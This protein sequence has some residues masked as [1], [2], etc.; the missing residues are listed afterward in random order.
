MLKMESRLPGENNINY[1][2]R[3]IK[4]AI[5]LLELQPG[6]LLNVGELSET[7]KVSSTPI[8]NAL[9]KL[10]QEHLV[11]LIPQVGS[12][13]SKIDLDLVEEAA[14]LWFVLEKEYLKLAC[15]FFPED[16]MNQLKKNL[17]SQE[18]LLNEQPISLNSNEW[19]GRF[20]ELDENFHSIIFQ[21]HHR[22]TT[23]KVIKQ[24]A[25]HYHRM[26]TLSRT[27]SHFKQ[28][29]AEHKDILSIIENKEI[30]RVESVLRNHILKPVH[31][32][33]ETHKNYF[34]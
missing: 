18:I 11:D 6:Q 19:L 27:D 23:W 32:W 9:W 24:T 33:R 4:E 30:E 2:Y 8:K 14:F 16:S 15:D 25:S 13:V 21:S 7:L 12:Y 34:C 22:N 17:D 3:V 5:L 28:I 31:N 10:Q 1:S 26:I 20:Y 29:I